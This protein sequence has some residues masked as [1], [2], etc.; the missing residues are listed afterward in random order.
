MLWSEGERDRP[1]GLTTG[2]ALGLGNSDRI[3]V[4]STG[5]WSGFRVISRGRT[6]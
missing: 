5:L 1:L 3:L 4:G 6:G 2:V